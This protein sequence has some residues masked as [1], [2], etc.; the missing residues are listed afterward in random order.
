MNR[1]A[2][3]IASFALAALAS[4]AQAATV[5]YSNTS[6]SIGDLANPGGHYCSSC[7]SGDFQV[8]QSY[9]LASAATINSISVIL[10]DIW[11]SKPVTLSFHDAVSGVPGAAYFSTSVSP[12]SVT[13]IGNNYS[14]V[15]YSGFSIA[16]GQTGYFSLFN[17]S[18]EFAYATFVNSPDKIFQS[19]NLDHAFDKHVDSGGRFELASDGA[20]PEPAT[21]AT[22]LLGFGLIGGAMRHRRRPKVTVR[23]T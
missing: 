21:W 9:S 14:K 11:A 22:M 16:A 1:R 13:S 10:F 2:L 19:Y 3:G 7:T 4:P 23:Y 12:T 5:I 8:F 18:S 6:F 17:G 15:T 20:V